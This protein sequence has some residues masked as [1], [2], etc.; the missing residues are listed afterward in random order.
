VRSEGNSRDI[1]S[2]SEKTYYQSKF[3]S[4]RIYESRNGDGKAAR[5]DFCLCTLH[6]SV[7]VVGG[8]VGKLTVTIHN[9]L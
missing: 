6:D 1:D 2:F 7:V 4:Q 3:F 9:K 8:E 5:R